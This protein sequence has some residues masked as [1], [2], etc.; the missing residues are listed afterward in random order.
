MSPSGRQEK[1]AKELNEHL[2]ST[3]F[4]LKIVNARLDGEIAGLWN[5]TNSTTGQLSELRN[6]WKEVNATVEMSSNFTDKV[7][8]KCNPRTD[9]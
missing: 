5:A 4:E 9:V 2:A 3:Q 7:T 8:S 1:N 6:V